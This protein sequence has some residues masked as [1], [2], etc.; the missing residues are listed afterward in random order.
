MLT[1]FERIMMFLGSI[2]CHQLDSRSIFINGQKLPYCARDTGIYVGFLMS[3]TYFVLRSKLKANKPLTIAQA[4]IVCIL[5]MPMMFDGITSY[6]GFRETTNGVRI[7]T[8]LLFGSCMPLLLLPIGNFSIKGKNNIRLISSP[9]EIIGLVLSILF[10][11]IFIY[12]LKIYYF[13]L[14]LLPCLGMLIFSL[15]LVYTPLKRLPKLNK[16]VRIILTIAIVSIFL[17]VYWTIGN[18]IIRPIMVNLK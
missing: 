2:T 15:M 17:G 4:V 9:L 18:Y 7:I 8:G 16:Y 6:L 5:L 13:I 1:I 14:A 11:G 3:L 10:I 12:N